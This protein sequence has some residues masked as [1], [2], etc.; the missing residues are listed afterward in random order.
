MNVIGIHAIT[1]RA[2]EL[3]FDRTLVGVDELIG[4]PRGDWAYLS[5]GFID[6]QVNG[7]AGVD[8]CDPETSLE[9]IARSLEAQF[10][11]GVT[12]LLPTVITG[13]PEHM[14]GALRNLARAKEELRYGHAIEGIHVEGPHISPEDGPRGAHPARWVRPPDVEEFHRWQDAARGYVRLVTLSPEWPEAP[15]YIESLVREGIVVSIGHTKATSA[16]IEDAVR[17]G[18]TK[19]THLGNGAHAMLPRHPNYIWDQLANDALAAGFIVDG[20]HLPA[21]FLKSAVRAKGVERSILVTDAVAPAGCEPGYYR[22]GEVEVELLAEGKVVMRGGTR[23]AGAALRMDT[24]IANTVRMAE[25]SLAD[26]LTM[27]TRNPARVARIANRM[28]GLEPGERADLVEFRFDPVQARMTV[29]RT[30][31][32]GELVYQRD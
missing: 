3:R 7:F 12:R 4:V 28:R 32:S 9:A 5:P 10:S 23:L 30:W 29:M 22:L 2:V 26:A 13:N 20:F 14:L 21:S 15:H 16:Q 17:A 24:A 1:H 11:T 31:L 18:A 8:Y 6:L 25:V 19:S 27:A